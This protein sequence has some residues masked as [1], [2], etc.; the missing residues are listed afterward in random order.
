M[1]H[2]PI[3][4]WVATQALK[5]DCSSASVATQKD[6]GKNFSL[7]NDNKTQLEQLGCLRSEDTSRHPMIAHTIDQFILD[8]M[9]IIL[10][11]IYWIPSQ[12]KTK[13]K[14]QF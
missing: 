4:L 12:N 3:F 8:L 2:L 10:T 1:F 5:Q 14:L 9:P 11:S 7:Q 6:L 13:S